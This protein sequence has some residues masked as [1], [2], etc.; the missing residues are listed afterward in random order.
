MRVRKSLPDQCYNVSQPAGELS[1]RWAGRGEVGPGPDQPEVLQVRISYVI[2]A[3]QKEET[4]DF[5]V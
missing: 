1:A 2:A 5:E 4:H 3:L